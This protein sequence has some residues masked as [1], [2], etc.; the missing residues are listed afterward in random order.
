M[1]GGASTDKTLGADEIIPK[2]AENQ[3]KLNSSGALPVV[4]AEKRSRYE[5]KVDALFVEKKTNESASTEQKSE[6][7]PA[8]Q[9]STF[10]EQTGYLSGRRDQKLPVLLYNEHHDL[11][12]TPAAINSA[13]PEKDAESLRRKS[14]STLSPRY[15]TPVL[16][17]A[18][19]SF[20]EI[21]EPVIQDRP[22]PG[23]QGPPIFD[24][25][26]ANGSMSGRLELASPSDVSVG[27]R[28]PSIFD[29]EER[30]IPSTSAL[31]SGAADGLLATIQLS[32][33]KGFEYQQNPQSSLIGSTPAALNV[34]K[35]SSSSKSSSK[36]GH[37]HNTSESRI[38]SG[39]RG[40][41]RSNT[42]TS[43]GVIHNGGH[44]GKSSKGSQVN[45]RPPGSSRSRQ[46]SADCLRSVATRQSPSE[47]GIRSYHSIDD[48]D[49][50]E[51]SFI[52]SFKDEVLSTK[53]SLVPPLLLN[54]NN[55]AKDVASTPFPRVVGMGL[56]PQGLR[57]NTCTPTAASSS[58]VAVVTP[59]TSSAL[60]CKSSSQVS[61]FSTGCSERQHIHTPNSTNSGTRPTP[62]SIGGS[63][64]E[65]KETNDVKRN[66]AKLPP[67][68]THAKPTTGDWLKKR[69]IVNN[70]I[71]LDTL[72]T[73]SYGEVDAF[74]ILQFYFL[75]ISANLFLLLFRHIFFL[76]L[77][78]PLFSL[79]LFPWHIF[80]FSSSIS[81]SFYRRMFCF[82][83]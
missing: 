53:R 41:P 68:M 11:L 63:L 16:R 35:P 7:L 48:L 54:V 22:L 64:Y 20:S 18:P 73:G 79:P 37:G 29:V 62:T 46:S 77:F 30:S 72:G 28:T 69:Y 81:E 43:L 5:T 78:P 23:Y 33:T 1:G 60:N 24:S 80:H 74:Y 8:Q 61:Q 55:T 52:E 38:H 14:Q 51:T 70:Y 13:S 71:L 76:I 27:L 82:V 59:S 17:V 75:S 3:L 15:L 21:G 2:K 47:S 49:D 67:T 6:I 10:I 65:V 39:S 19:S 57:I 45:P 83:I 50:L 4:N 9:R 42:A 34:L 40:R 32:K 58:E 66:R 25:V 56:A 44:T 26:T 31:P 12:R 36:K